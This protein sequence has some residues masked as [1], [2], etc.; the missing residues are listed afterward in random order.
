MDDRRPNRPP[1]DVVALRAGLSEPWR[2][3]DVV[4]E[5]GSTNADLLARAAGGEAIGGAVL[6]AEYQ[7]AGRGRHGRQWSAPPR[8]QLALSVGVDASGVPA[9]SWGWLPLATGVAVVDAV[10]E[11]TGVRV[12]LKWPNDVLVGP[13][14][15][16]LAGILAEVA[17]PAPVVVVGLGL[18]VS[19]TAEEAPDARAT[20]LSQLGAGTV[21]RNPLA[22]ALLRHL[23]VRFE[24]WRASDPKLAA[25]YRAR[26]V[27]I[28]SGVR[29]ILPGDNELV[30]TAVDVDAVGRL[31][32]DTGTERVTVSAGDIT[33]LRP[34][35]P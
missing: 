12:G 7:N 31:I 6:L 3:L 11:V 23:A 27:T 19:M 1:L 34:D 10:A 21:D 30:G 4:E 15:G 26:S 25:D 29:A 2:R 33:H 22:R 16:K 9:D 5:T 32:I 14:G 28:G 17:S 24:G 13:A 35:Q 8:S 20:S 18:N